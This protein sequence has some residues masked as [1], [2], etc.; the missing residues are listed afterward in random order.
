MKHD[1]IVQQ[2]IPIYE[3]V[4]IPDE[5][6]P[7]DGRVEIDAKIHSVSYSIS[8]AEKH[9][10][11]GLTKAGCRDTVSARPRQHRLRLT[12]DPRLVTTGKAID[13]AELEQVQGRPWDDV[14]VGL[15]AGLL[16]VLKANWISSIEARSARIPAGGAWWHLPDHSG[17]S[18]RALSAEMLDGNRVYLHYCA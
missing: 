15:D 6:V 3:R 5:L 4:P 17:L 10:R 16:G 9:G 14:D 13:L 2:G 11:T 8:L 1:A 18:G 12:T 7:E